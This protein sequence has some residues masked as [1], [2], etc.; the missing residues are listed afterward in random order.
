MKEFLLESDNSSNSTFKI[1][2]K[3]NYEADEISSSKSNLFEFDVVS[4]TLK[5]VY[6]KSKIRK[7]LAFI[8]SILYSYPLLITILSFLIGLLTFG[9]SML[10][11]YFK[12][13]NNIVI[14]VLFPLILTLIFCICMIVIR[15]YDDVKYRVNYGAK[16]ERKNIL[17]NIGLSFTLIILTI[18]AILF[19]I[20]F[21]KLINYTNNK[22]IRFDIKINNNTKESYYYDFI[23]KYI[24]NCFLIKKE[25]IKNKEDEE[26]INEFDISALKN[27]HKNLIFSF[28][29]L[30]IFCI[31]K[32]IKIILIEVKYT[33]PKAIVYSNFFVLIILIFVSHNFY[34]KKKYKWLTISIIEIV[35]LSLI[36]IGYIFWIINSAYKLNRNPKDKNFAISKYDSGILLLIVVF[37]LLNVAGSSFIYISFIIN[38]VKYKDNS[39]CYKDLEKTLS[40]LKIGFLLCVL[41]NSY[42]YGHQILS[43][44][45]R[46]ISI[47]YAPVKLKKF[48][49]KANKNLASYIYS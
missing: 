15:I 24:I 29:P 42:Y 23:L 44:I 49:I 36:Y 6:S 28:I 16:W 43:I 18:A 20:F 40:T 13:F 3:A 31:S 39:E 27:L 32:I 2:R 45:F 21:K 41:S 38:F 30:A 48:Y 22:K 11:I 17:Q 4:D 46:P 33:I 12:I 7:N 5:H 34:D 8:L 1:S 9:L 37:D 47:Q 19:Y 26:I 25:I 14:P 35:L 10:F